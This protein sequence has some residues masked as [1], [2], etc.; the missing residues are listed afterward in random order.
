MR[1]VSAPS[2]FINQ[3]GSPHPS[4]GVA[5]AASC[6]TPTR[7]S[8]LPA[9]PRAR[10]AASP[11]GHRRLDRPSEEGDRARRERGKERQS[12]QPRA[13]GTVDRRV[14]RRRV[15]VD[16]QQTAALGHDLHSCDG[17]ARIQERHLGVQGRE[18]VRQPGAHSSSDGRSA[19]V[20]VEVCRPHH[21]IHDERARTCRRSQ[22]YEGSH[23]HGV[24]LHIHVVHR[25]AR[26][27]RDPGG[28]AEGSD[29]A[30]LHGGHQQRF[31][32]CVHL[33]HNARVRRRL[34]KL[35]VDVQA[36][37]GACGVV[38]VL[39]A[40]EAAHRHRGHDRH[41]PDLAAAVAAAAGG[42]PLDAGARCCQGLADHLAVRQGHLI[43]EI[44]L[45]P[46]TGRS[47]LDALSRHVRG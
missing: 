8:T 19:I 29:D 17:L 23:A 2:P 41:L 21:R 42:L 13:S 16:R 28:G 20:R 39:I 18:L 11:D 31:R 6:Y 44:V 36:A 37:V 25:E 1:G 7:S 34:R 32:S 4:R 40:R 14:G 30:T 9:C 26:H 47:V 3:A 33:R 24:E 45:V 35:P 10:G 12:R 27:S 5:K 46:A 43:Q 15:R 22:H 38:L